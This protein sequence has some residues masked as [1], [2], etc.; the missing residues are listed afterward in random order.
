MLYPIHVVRYTGLCYAHIGTAY[1]QQGDLDQALE[2]LGRA[3]AIQDRVLGPEHPETAMTLYNMGLL[4]HA[5]GL[6]D[7]ALAT[8][9]QV[10]AVCEAVYG[11]SHPETADCYFSIGLALQAKG[12][13]DVALEQHVKAVAIRCVALDITI[14]LPSFFFAPPPRARSAALLSCQCR[15]A[16]RS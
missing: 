7:R 5:Q 11:T 13:L 6:Y 14:C 4:Y 3:R 12:E 15:S 10:L 1:G 8:H 9:L 2:Y 16:R